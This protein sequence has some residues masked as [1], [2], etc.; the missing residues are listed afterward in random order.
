MVD[1]VVADVTVIEGEEAEE[2]AVGNEVED[3]MVHC[4]SVVD[5][6]ACDLTSSAS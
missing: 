2:I 1:E 5:T 3:G 6:A 4:V